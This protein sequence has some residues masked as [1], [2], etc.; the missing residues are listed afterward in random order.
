MYLLENVPLPFFKNGTVCVCSYE[1]IVDWLQQRRPADSREA[2]SAQGKLRKGKSPREAAHG[3]VEQDWRRENKKRVEQMKDRI[4]ASWSLR[5]KLA[6]I[7]KHIT[8]VP[9]ELRNRYFSIPKV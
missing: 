5:K 4:E 2:S 3:Q 6:P 7:K 8:T 1:F 9:N